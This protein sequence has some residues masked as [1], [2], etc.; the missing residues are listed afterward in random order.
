MGHPSCCLNYNMRKWVITLHSRKIISILLALTL[1]L[2][3]CTVSFAAETAIVSPFTD[4]DASAPDY[5]AILKAHNEGLISGYG[6]GTFRPNGLLTRAELYQI[7]AKASSVETGEADGHWAGKAIN[8]FKTEGVIQSEEAPGSAYFNANITRAEAVSATYR[9]LYG[10]GLDGNYHVPD[11]MDQSAIPSEYA[12]DIEEAYRTGLL[13]GSNFST[14]FFPNGY[15]S[16]R[17]FCS[18]LANADMSF[19]ATR[20]DIPETQKVILFEVKGNGFQTV[21]NAKEQTVTTLNKGGSILY[22]LNDT[23]KILGEEAPGIADG[24]SSIMFHGSATAPIYD[25]PT[26]YVTT[27][28]GTFQCGADYIFGEDN[29]TV[30]VPGGSN[31]LEKDGDIFLSGVALSRMTRRTFADE[32][33]TLKVLVGDSYPD[34]LRQSRTLSVEEKQTLTDSLWL[35][36]NTFDEG[37][38]IV[39]TYVNSVEN[40]SDSYMD[41]TTGNARSLA[42][43]PYDQHT[44]Q[45]R[46]GKILAHSVEINAA[47]LVHEGTHFKQYKNGDYSEDQ[48]TLYEGMTH[49]YIQQAGFPGT[50]LNTLLKAHGEVTDPYHNGVTLLQQWVSDQDPS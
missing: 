15:F 31:Y 16:R 20:W 4:V 44:V 9:V 11:L 34:F 27:S 2:S 49:Y 30:M 41:R 17:E 45:W 33:G 43:A 7:L 36:Y 38:D 24:V 50:Y 13:R 37:Y 1:I 21:G 23:A 19:P 46:K 48:T 42:C 32:D 6:D 3:L 26:A 12:A 25:V 29:S 35:V 47:T 5:D 10:L 28:R 22:S 14:R 39:T 40:A 18:V 8:H